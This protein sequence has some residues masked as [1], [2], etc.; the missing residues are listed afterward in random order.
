VIDDVRAFAWG[1]RGHLIEAD[2]A[3][4]HIER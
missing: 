2:L 4:V 1:R 3:G